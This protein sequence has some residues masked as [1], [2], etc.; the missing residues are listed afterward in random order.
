[1][2]L[3]NFFCQLKMFRTH[4]LHFRPRIQQPRIANCDKFSEIRG[5]DC[6]P[7][8]VFRGKYFFRQ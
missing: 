8:W 3:S 5:E 1:M 7:L 4:I 2:N 6:D